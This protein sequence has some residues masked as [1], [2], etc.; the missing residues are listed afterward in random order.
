MSDTEKTWIWEEAGDYDR[1]TAAER[2]LYYE[3]YHDLLDLVVVRCRVRRGDRVLDIGTGTGELARRFVQNRGCRV[4]GLDPSPAMV[5]EA[6]RKA[7]QAGWGDAE[8]QV[9][10]APFLEIPYPAGAFDAVASSQAFHHLHERHKPEAVRE[11]ARVLGS[12]GWLA[13]GDPMFQ[14]QADLEAALARWPEELEEE[15]FAY[16]ETLEPMFRSAGLSYHA[17]RLSRINCVVWGQKKLSG[18]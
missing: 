7:K 11:M 3:R 5:E 1:W 4:V 10:E 9:V 2:G 8:F 15:Y 16:L 18:F 6:R 12:G 13:I 14:D 17:E